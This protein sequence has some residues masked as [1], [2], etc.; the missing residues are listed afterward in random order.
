MTRRMRLRLYPVTNC[1]C[2]STRVAF[3]CA[4]TSRRHDR[5]RPFHANDHWQPYALAL[6]GPARWCLATLLAHADPSTK[7][8]G[9]RRTHLGSPVSASSRLVRAA[10]LLCSPPAPGQPARLQRR[11]PKPVTRRRNERSGRAGS[12]PRRPGAAR[13]ALAGG[14]LHPLHAA[15]WG[16]GAA[17]T[18]FARDRYSG[19]K[20]STGQPAP[21]WVSRLLPGAKWV[22]EKVTPPILIDLARY[23]IRGR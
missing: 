13:V 19:L 17:G 9:A 16:G 15:A 10:P 3:R 7:T 4:I 8:P 1:R 20:G 12:G 2:L 11:V 18:I 14:V 6:S 23:L 5:L 22:V 21:S